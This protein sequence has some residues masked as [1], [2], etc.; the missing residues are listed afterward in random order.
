MN[1]HEPAAVYYYVWF[2]LALL[3]LIFWLSTIGIFHGLI[4]LLF[5]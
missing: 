2:G 4:R 3:C 5:G 1:N